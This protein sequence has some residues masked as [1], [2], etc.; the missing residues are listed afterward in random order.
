L[1]GWAAQGGLQWSLAIKGRTRE[2]KAGHMGK[3]CCSLIAKASA[4]PCF[5]PIEFNTL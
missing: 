1:T 2:E 3:K 5:W 4:L